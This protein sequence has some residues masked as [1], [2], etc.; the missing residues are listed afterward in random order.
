MTNRN[1]Q[2]YDTYNDF[3]V[4]YFISPDFW[5]GFRNCHIPV[6]I[7]AGYL[8]ND[9]TSGGVLLSYNDMINIMEGLTRIT[10]WFKIRT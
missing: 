8:A 10:D 6:H 5:W 2:D 4:T 1:L 9:N 3:I 7:K